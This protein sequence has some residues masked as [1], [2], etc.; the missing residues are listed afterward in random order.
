M[1]KGKG[2]VQLLKRKTSEAR[3]VS[4]K[5]QEKRQQNKQ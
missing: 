1:G 2:V 5:N 3:A 4:R